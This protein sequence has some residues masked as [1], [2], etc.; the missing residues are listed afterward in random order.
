MADILASVKRIVVKIGSSILVENQEIASHRIEALCKFVADLQAKY[1]VILVTSGAVAAGF[2][3]KEMDKSFVP[4]KQALASMGQ[5]LLMHMYYTEFQ[6]Y[7][8]PCAQ[9]LLGAYDLDSR[10]R[11]VNAHN[12]IEVLVSH[13]VIPIINENDATALSELVFGDNDRLSAHVA[14]HFKADLLVI[15]SDI[16]GYY[17]ANPR[18]CPGAEMRLVVHSLRADEL[19]ADATPNNQFATGGIVTK[20]QAAQ[21]L[22]DHGGK[23]FL[24]SG[25]QLEKARA[26]LLDGL[27]ESGTLFAP[28]A[29]ASA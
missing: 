23:M 14:H 9:M 25:F 28:Q 16:D 20:L 11:T 19:V 8:I 6:K 5:P 10:K 4:N 26:F 17:T 21:F 18:T 15:L 12:A 3:E 22:L 7:N 1:E 24:S 13:K 29:L 2:T 27:H